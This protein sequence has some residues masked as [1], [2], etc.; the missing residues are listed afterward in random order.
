MKRLAALLAATGLIVVTTV[1]ASSAARSPKTIKAI[2]RNS[3][4]RNALIQSTFRFAQDRVVVATN[5]TIKFTSASAG[6]EPHTLT[7]IPKSLRPNN[8]G[9]VFGCRYCQ[10]VL[11]RH[12]STHSH[13]LNAG[14]AGLNQRGDSLFAAAHKSISA[15][16]TAPK[17]S[18]LYFV[19]AVHPWMQGKILVR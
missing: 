17:G 2:G 18:T 11:R 1:V 9:D 16:V 13:R 5:E 4:L 7:I 14:A 3:F 6:P 19:C 12:S 15:K 10:K 8:V